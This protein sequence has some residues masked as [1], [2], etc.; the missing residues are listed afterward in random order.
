MNKSNKCLIFV[1]NWQQC[2]ETKNFILNSQFN[3]ELFDVFIFDNEAT[4]N[5]LE[6]FKKNSDLFSHYESSKINLG[7]AEPCNIGL[8]FAKKNFYEYILFINTDSIFSNKDAECLFNAVKNHKNIALAS[9]VIKD[10]KDSSIT[11]SGATFD[12]NKRIILHSDLNSISDSLEKHRYLLFG[13]AILGRINTLLEVNGFY[14]PFFAYWEDFLVCDKLIS[15]GY[16]TAIVKNSSIYHKNDRSDEIE[17]S[18]SQY[19]YYYLTRN[20]VVF[21]R[22]VSSSPLK[23]LYWLICRS[24]SI[25]LN[26]FLNGR[27]T[28]AKSVLV[29]LFHGFSGKLGKWEQQL[30]KK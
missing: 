23:P 10:M 4:K 9:P 12:T 13:T 19:Y 6:F 17:T 14:K 5:T 2:E 30:Q 21:W 18:K 28:Q 22:K 1:I 29:G 15:A 7:F 27:K 8:N 16:A 11:Y 24:F 20:E 25:S 26:L 3:K